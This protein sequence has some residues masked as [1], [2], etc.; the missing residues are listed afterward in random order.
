MKRDA[1][2]FF[3]SE[4]FELFSD[5]DPEYIFARLKSEVAVALAEEDYRAAVE[6]YKNAFKLLEQVEAHVRSEQFSSLAPNVNPEDFLSEMTAK[7]PLRP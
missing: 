7:Y 4:R 2:E 1:E 3:H 5:A 6:M